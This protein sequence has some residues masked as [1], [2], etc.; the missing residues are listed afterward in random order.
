[1]QSA[2]KKLKNSKIFKTENNSLIVQSKCSVC[3]IKKSRFVKKQEAKELFSSPGLK[4]PLVKV[5][6]LGDV[7]F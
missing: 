6:L 1:M 7:L 3:E 2:R 5:S 4:T